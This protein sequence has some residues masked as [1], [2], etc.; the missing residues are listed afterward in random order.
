MKKKTSGELGF[1]CA[2]FLMAF[3]SAEKLVPAW[4]VGHDSNQTE[5][6]TK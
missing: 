3:G 5:A 4:K 1:F 2:V 6:T